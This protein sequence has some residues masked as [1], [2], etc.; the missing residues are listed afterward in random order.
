MPLL[1]ADRIRSKSLPNSEE[2]NKIKYGCW[3][4]FCC[5]IACINQKIQMDK[6]C[7][8]ELDKYMSLKQRI[9][10]ESNRY[11]RDTLLNEANAVLDS[12][13]AKAE[14]ILKKEIFQSSSTIHVSYLNPIK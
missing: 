2:L 14:D 1:S 4:N 13:N 12:M 8:P 7:A 9:L 6:Q 5:N 11:N 3:M 10:Q